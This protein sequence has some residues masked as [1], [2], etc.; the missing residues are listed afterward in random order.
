MINLARL[1]DAD[2]RALRKQVEDQVEA[3]LR[4]ATERIAAARFA[5]LGTKTFP[6]ATFTLRLNYGTVRGWKEG[7]RDVAPMTQLSRL[8]E[9]ATGADPFRVPES[10]LAM[11]EQLDLTT[12]F[13][14]STTNDIVGGNSGSPLVNARGELV[15]LMFDGNIH[16]IS[17]A[18][19]FDTELNRA[20]AVHPAIMKVALE[21]VYRADAL[22]K[23][24]S[25]SQ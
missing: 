10:W 4:V 19:W 21:K 24:L 6:D 15:G 25:G 18:F 5:I 17:G 9:R 16:S 2:A 8:F 12:P 7:N 13:N 14:F 11:R 22:L 3:P 1:I 20:V 23:E